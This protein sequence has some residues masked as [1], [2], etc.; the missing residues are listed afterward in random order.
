MPSRT[1]TWIARGL[2]LLALGLLAAGW[3][4]A[5]I[6]AGG[7]LFDLPRIDRIVGH[8]VDRLVQAVGVVLEQAHDISPS[9]DPSSF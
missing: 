8:L 2:G 7:G 5:G 1:T 3:S 4:I 9:S 6:D